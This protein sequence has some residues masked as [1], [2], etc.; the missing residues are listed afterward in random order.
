MNTQQTL[1]PADITNM[2]HEGKATLIDVRDVSELQSTG[3]ADGAI[4]IPLMM[5]NT[6]ANPKHPEFDTRLDLSRP[7]FLYCASGARSGM[8]AQAL[9]QFG[10]ADVMN[11]GGLANWVQAGGDRVP[12][13]P[14]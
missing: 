12:F 5:I 14:S 13:A 7:V 6:K 8:A 10:F 4:H 9:S 3:T 11:L 2:V 1:T